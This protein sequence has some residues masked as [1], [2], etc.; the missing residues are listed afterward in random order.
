GIHG[1]N[2]TIRSGA[3]TTKQNGFDMIDDLVAAVKSGNRDTLGDVM[4]PRIDNFI[5]N[6]LSVM[7]SNGAL[8]NRYNTN[9]ERLTKDNVVMTDSY[10]KL[11]K[12][13]PA[14]VATQM[15]MAS[16]MYQANLSVISQLIQPS[17]LDFLH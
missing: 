5:D 17:L 16:Y 4:L 9:V 12:V 11:V 1:Q 8:Q 14:D 10:D 15:M 7:S 6:L 13:D 2:A 3:N